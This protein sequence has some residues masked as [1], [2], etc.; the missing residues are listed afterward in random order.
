MRPTAAEDFNASIISA[1]RTKQRTAKSHRPISKQIDDMSSY[2]RNPPFVVLVK[3]LV[4]KT[5]EPESGATLSHPCLVLKL[6]SC[7]LTTDA[8]NAWCA[9]KYWDFQIESI[10]VDPKRFKEMAKAWGLA[11]SLEHL[12][13]ATGLVSAVRISFPEHVWRRGDPS[14]NAD[15]LVSSY[16]SKKEEII[17][18]LMAQQLT[19]ENLSTAAPF[20]PPPPAIVGNSGNGLIAPL[21]TQQQHGADLC[22]DGPGCVRDGTVLAPHDGV[23]VVGGRGQG[24][25]TTSKTHPEVAGGL[26][27]L[28]LELLRTM[29][30]SADEESV[31]GDTPPDAGTPEDMQPVAF[32]CLAKRCSGAPDWSLQAAGD[33]APANGSNDS[34]SGVADALPMD[35]DLSDVADINAI[36]D[37]MDN[38]AVAMRLEELIGRIGG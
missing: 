6:P 13:G 8:A 22:E 17:Q 11:I 37:T 24:A 27:P 29:D 21:L 25:S 1:A 16:N 31:G 38:E 35:C 2:N 30:T 10:G 19:A 23:G 26:C 9:R 36:D 20:L 3:K 15:F 4:R 5:N 12:A 34:P 28:V 7:H 18:D 14:P 33:G 32:D